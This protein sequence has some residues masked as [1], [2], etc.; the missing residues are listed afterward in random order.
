M[1]PAGETRRG[2]GNNQGFCWEIRAGGRFDVLWSKKRI[3]ENGMQTRRRTVI[4]LITAGQI[5]EADMPL[6]EYCIE[7]LQSEIDDDVYEEKDWEACFDE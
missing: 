6:C 1:P 3:D 7:K 5:V 4:C 2:R